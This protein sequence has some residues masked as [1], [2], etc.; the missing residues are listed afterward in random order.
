[1]KVTSQNQSIF[2]DV[3]ALE[4]YLF[5]LSQKDYRTIGILMII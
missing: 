5:A 4:E 1:M 2:K 3:T